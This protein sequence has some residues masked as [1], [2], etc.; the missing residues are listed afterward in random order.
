MKLASPACT[1]PSPRRVVCTLARLALILGSIYAASMVAL[2]VVWLFG[3]EV[4]SGLLIAAIGASPVLLLP[5]YGLLAVAV[6]LRRYVLLAASGVLVS[7]QIAAVLAVVPIGH[8]STGVPVFKVLDANLRFTNQQT[9]SFGDEIVRM[10]PDLLAL[11][12]LT[13]TTKKGLAASLSAFP[14]HVEQISYDASGIGLYSR[15]EISS[16]TTGFLGPNPMI[17]ATVQSPLGPI[18]VVVVHTN[19]PRA[20]LAI[21][22][23]RAEFQQMSPIASAL[24][25]LA[26][27][28]GDFNA[29]VLNMPLRK[30]MAA[31]ALRDSSL[32]AGVP[33][34]R[35]WPRDLRI[36]PP[37]LGI[38]HI[39]TSRGLAAAQAGAIDDSG[40]DHR[41]IWADIGP[42][43]D[44]R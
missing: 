36:I 38:D 13:P 16:S 24:P 33:W 10:R 41:A 25:A 15:Y 20:G 28:V 44:S 7:L 35:T 22:Q 30:V 4:I 26:L 31:G 14:F 6:V 27:V 17:R 37:I 9:A 3:W 8:S 12:E 11:E 42:R 34:M 32:E 1:S 29:T 2:L 43:G 23:W 19:A 18:V 5:A 39:L 40:S 21:K